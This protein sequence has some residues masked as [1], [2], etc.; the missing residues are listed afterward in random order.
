[1]TFKKTSCCGTNAATLAE[2]QRIKEHVKERY[3]SRVKTGVQ[4]DC[5]PPAKA[6]VDVVAALSAGY[7]EEQLAAVPAHARNILSAAQSRGPGRHPTRSDGSRHRLRRGDRRAACG[8]QGGSPRPRHRARH[9]AGD[10]QRGKKE[11]HRSR[12]DERRVPPGRRRGHAGRVRNR[13]LDHQQLRDQPGA[14]QRQGVQRGLPL[15]RPGGRILVRT[16]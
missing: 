14:G 13:G 2:P 3:G 12:R 7:T 4:G 11:R 6:N 15:L 16:S 10:D 5:C 9:D 8:A 1:M